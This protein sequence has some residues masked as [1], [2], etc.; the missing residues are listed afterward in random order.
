MAEI[1][2]AYPT[3]GGSELQDEGVGWGWDVWP[4]SSASS[5]SWRHQ[6]RAAFINADFEPLTTF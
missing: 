3:L 2:S 6:L 5:P 4:T 1:A